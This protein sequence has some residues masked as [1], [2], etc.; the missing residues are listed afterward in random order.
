MGPAGLQGPMVLSMR[1][2][3][4]RQMLI[5][6]PPYLY[7]QLFPK[8]LWRIGVPHKK[9]VYLTFDDGQFQR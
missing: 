4:F 3:I 2:Q 6:Q 5:E 7:R 8:S 9:S 1:N